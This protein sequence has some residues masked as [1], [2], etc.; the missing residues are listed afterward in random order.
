MLKRGFKTTNIC[1]IIF[2]SLVF[3]Y[4]SFAQQKYTVSGYIKEASSGENLIGATVYIKE[5][6]KNTVSNSYGFY[7]LT[8]DEGNYILVISYLGFLTQQQT[9]ALNNNLRININLEFRPIETE[10]VVITAEKEDKNIE[11]TKMSTVELNVEEIKVLP[12]FLGEVDVLK[13]IQLLP[14]VLSAGE[15][16]SGFYVRG[17]GPDQNLILLDEAVV[18]N[19]SHLFGFFSVFNADAINN[20]SLIKGGMPAN[21]GGRLASV[22]DISM[23]EGNIKKF[24]AEGGVGLISSRITLQGPIYKDKSSFIITGRRT[25]A[26]ALIKPFVNKKSTARNSTYYFYDMNAKLNYKLSDKDR[27][28]L[29]GYFGRDVFLFKSSL[30]DFEV[31]IPWGNATT[32]L[33]WNHLFNDKLFMNAMALYSNYQFEL[34][35]NFGQFEFTLFS[36]ITDW[37]AKVDFDYFPNIKHRIKFGSNYTYHTFIPSSASGKSGTVE[38]KPDKINKQYANDAALYIVD[39]FDVTDKI[40]LNAGIRYTLFQHIGPWDQYIP[41]QDGQITDTIIYK[42]GENIAL[43]NGFDP[44]F[45]IRYLL[46]SVSSLKASYTYI[47]QFLH[48]ASVSGSTLPTDIWV[49]SSKIVKPQ[50]GTQYAIGYFRNFLNNVIESSIEIY[51]KDMKNQIEYRDGAVPDINNNTENDFI[52]GKGYAYGAELFVKKAKGKLQGWVG[53]TLAWTTRQF[54]DTNDGK[55]YPAKYDRRHDLVIVASYTLNPKWIFSS[56]FIFATGNA[57]WL[58]IGRYFIEEHIVDE[59]GERNNFRVSPYNR[60][61]ISATYMRKKTEKFQS[62][63]N[64]AVYN[65]YNSH[66]TFFIFFSSEGELTEGTFK[67]KATRVYFPVMPSVT[68]NF[69]F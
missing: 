61:D 57:Y 54:D 50:I 5:L 14:G 6:N 29:S 8:L 66:N 1:S 28:F 10:E 46:N 19:A 3:Q 44:R 62:S 34:N 39:E 38:F 56:S 58:P 18:Y 23:K 35:A 24:H 40:K 67:T 65:T 26:D 30:S 25:Y 20:V 51:Y 68:W 53:Y 36:G 64:F 33:R 55:P 49:P 63:W 12:A 9:I 16:N 48:L 4:S 2:L 69:K 31:G 32:T 43:Y 15:G 27:L 13:T 52:F 47:H 42:P 60:L 45:S 7:S 21:Y 59:Y 22:L 41:N 17:G 11:T 37:N